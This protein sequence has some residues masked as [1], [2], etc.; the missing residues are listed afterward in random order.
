MAAISRGQ[1]LLRSNSR[2][3]YHLP[4]VMSLP[5]FIGITSLNSCNFLSSSNQGHL[6]PCTSDY[7]KIYLW[8]AGMESLKQWWSPTQGQSRWGLTFI[9]DCKYGSV[10]LMVFTRHKSH[11]TTFLQIHVPKSTK[12]KKSQFYVNDPNCCINFEKISWAVSKLRQIMFQL[13]RW[14]LPTCN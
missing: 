12:D 8:E 13:I 7:P 1:S 6:P 2:K 14:Q 11:W 10:N 9:V 4:N 3:R 5:S